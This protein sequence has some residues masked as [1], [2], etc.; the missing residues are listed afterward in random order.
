[1]EPET[2]EG[3][4]GPD[5]ARGAAGPARHDTRRNWSKKARHG[6]R[7]QI[8]KILAMYA[9]G[10]TTRDIQAQWQEL[11]GVEGSPALICNVA[12]AVMEEVQKTAN[13]P[14]RS[15]LSDC[16][17][18]LPGG[19]GQGEPTRKSQGGVFGAGS[20]L[21]REQGEASHVALLE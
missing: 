1:H 16:V 13:A 15:D 2:G 3:R 12:E 11:Y 21:G 4:A 20:H 10:M 18:G 19:Q 8:A 9:R 6:W 14:A 7:A 17:S 5:R